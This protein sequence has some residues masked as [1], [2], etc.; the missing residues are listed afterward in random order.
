MATK[1]LAAIELTG[2]AVG[3]LDNI[4]AAE[5][6]VGDLALVIALDPNDG[7]TRLVYFYRFEAS[8]AAEDSPSVIAPDD[9]PAGPNRWILKSAKYIRN[10]VTL[11]KTKKVNTEYIKAIDSDGL[12]LHNDGDQGI[13]IQDNNSV[14]MDGN[15]AVSGS[16]LGYI[17]YPGKLERGLTTLSN[18]VTSASI[19]F[20]DTKSNTAYT[21]L[22]SI[23]NV[24]DVSA[25]QF[26]T[27][28]FAKR[29][30]GFDI[31]FSDAID[32]TGYKLNWLV[33]DY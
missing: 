3:A 5:L 33:I 10:D 6:S 14:V 29:T 27:L 1:I 26:S 24:S 19:S 22:P 12:K 25:S 18:G 17:D 23:E 15:L 11:L 4:P 16:I 21:V 13:F 9:A 30:T 28:V 31:S 8:A 32:G 7:T 2:G 20:T